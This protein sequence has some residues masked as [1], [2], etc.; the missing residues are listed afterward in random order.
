MPSIMAGQ[1]ISTKKIAR[2]Y[3]VSYDTVRK[4]RINASNENPFP[5]VVDKQILETGG[6]ATFMFDAQS[7]DIWVTDFYNKKGK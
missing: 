3:F 1:G 5:L 7:V 4:W 2:K 6:R